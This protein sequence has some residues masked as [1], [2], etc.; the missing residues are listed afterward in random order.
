MAHLSIPLRA[1]RTPWWRSVW[2][3]AVSNVRTVA[4]LGQRMLRQIKQ[5]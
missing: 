4:W 2:R 5:R 3:Q 1:R